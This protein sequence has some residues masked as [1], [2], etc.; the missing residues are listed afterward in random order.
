M[1]LPVRHY[2]CYALPGQ[3]W[4]EANFGHVSREVELDPAATAFVTVDLWN[5]GWLPQPLDPALGRDAEYHFI[6]LGRRAAEEGKRVTEENLAPALNAA[7]R[8]GLTIVHSNMP[9]IVA[10]YPDNA[11]TAPAAS[12]AP[13]AGAEPWPPWEVDQQ[14]REDYVTYTWGP[15]A[16]DRWARMRELADFP[17]PV[18]PQA[19]DFVVSEQPALDALLRERKIT[20]VIHAGFLLGH[21]LLDRVGGIR[22]T[23]PAWRYP[24]YRDILLR[25][26]TVA[27]ES[28]E[29]IAGF[30]TT[31]A[32]IFWLEATGVPTSTAAEFV[33]ACPR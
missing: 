26:C 17:E 31:K 5:M 4:D 29:S 24:G 15:E 3:E 27:Q 19:G 7:R 13:T 9:Q 23:A 12:E 20:T 2:R 11:Y 16:E 14:V 30:Q 8:A 33:A 1:L 6:G 28:H 22:H 21:C 10:K 18:K 32:F 25:D